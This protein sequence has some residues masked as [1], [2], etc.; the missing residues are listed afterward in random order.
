MDLVKAEIEKQ[1][2]KLVTSGLLPGNKK[3]FKRSLLRQKEEEEYFS[4]SKR[5]KEQSNNVE[6]YNFRTKTE[7]E[8]LLLKKF[9]ERSREEREKGKLMPR[10]EVVRLLRERNQPIRLFGE[11]DYD[12]FQR[13]KRVQLLEPE[14]KG[15]RNDL[16]AALDKLDDA[17]DEEFYTSGRGVPASEPHCID[18]SS[19]SSTL[20][21]KTKDNTL[22]VEELE[23][24]K[25]DLARYVTLKEG[26][27]TDDATTAVVSISKLAPDSVCISDFDEGFHDQVIDH[28]LRYLKRCKN[29]I[30][31][32]LVKIM[33][34]MI[35][36][37]YLKANDA[38]LE[39]AIGNA[40]WPLG[41]TNHGIHS[42]TAQEKIYAKNVAHVLNDET[43]RKYIQAIKR[44]MTQCQ[45][46]FP[47][48]PS[49]SVNYMGT[50]G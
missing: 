3:F 15:L 1:R 13:L 47:S 26:T 46:F 25:I 11:S 40:P 50:V 9:E 21:V 16:I 10:K 5:P 27:A 41:V 37:N 7:E 33:V 35:D 32:S 44:L 17:E 2:K 28:T 6:D 36:R 39:L 34:L 29:D 8:D 38:Y 18:S 49:K 14:S 23:K 31:N 19:A 42:R 12:T 45:K 48:D 22:T 4:K 20:D 24:M 43:Q 30:L